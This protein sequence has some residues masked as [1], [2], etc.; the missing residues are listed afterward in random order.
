M[1]HRGIDDRP[2]EEAGVADDLVVHDVPSCNCKTGGPVQPHE[3]VARHLEEMERVNVT[4]Q[5]SAHVA[6]AHAMAAVGAIN[7][8]LVPQP[9]K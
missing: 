7:Q 6:L 9:A 1:A 8:G 2:A 3:L 5:T 4:D